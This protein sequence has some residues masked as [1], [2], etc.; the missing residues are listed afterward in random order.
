[1][2]GSWGIPLSIAPFRCV[3]PLVPSQTLQPVINA[4]KAEGGQAGSAL[5]SC[6]GPA[7]KGN[8]PL[9]FPPRLCSA[10]ARSAVFISMSFS[11][12]CEVEQI[13]SSCSISKC[14]LGIPSADTL[15]D[16]MMT[17]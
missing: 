8:H 15:Q 11:S 3:D 9:S 10:D 13:R 5:R 12:R 17:F 7:T 14:P 1:M 6:L 4:K 16:I 2:R